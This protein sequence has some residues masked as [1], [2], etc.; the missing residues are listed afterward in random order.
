LAVLVQFENAM[1]FSLPPPCFSVLSGSALSAIPV[2][3]QLFS[4]KT[5]Q[6]IH[7]NLKSTH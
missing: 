4:L 5:A 3:K 2:S 1:F 6:I 7:N